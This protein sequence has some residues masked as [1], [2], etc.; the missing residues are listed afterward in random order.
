MSARRTIML[1]FLMI[2][3]HAFKEVGNHKCVILGVASS[4]QDRTHTRQLK[5]TRR[6]TQYNTTKDKDIWRDENK[7]EAMRKRDKKRRDE[8]RRDEK[9]T[10]RNI[11][12]HHDTAQHGTTQVWKKNWLDKKNLSMTIHQ[13]YQACLKYKKKRKGV[14]VTFSL[15]FLMHCVLCCVVLC[16]VVL[17][18]PDLVCFVLFCFVLFCFVLFCLV[19]FGSSCLVF[20]GLVLSCLVL[21]CLVLSCHVMSCLVLP[22]LSCRALSC[23]VFSCLVCLALTWTCDSSEM[24]WFGK[25]A[26]ISGV[27]RRVQTAL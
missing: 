15:S 9:T 3:P 4:R 6:H 5:T 17:F 22:A 23:L 19:L 10:Q 20:S 18:C 7:Q 16:C 2:P 21:S 25:Y 13:V 26:G 14:S 8:T 1:K 11:R 12:R 24:S 27:R